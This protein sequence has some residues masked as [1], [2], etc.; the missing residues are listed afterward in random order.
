MKT[1]YSVLFLLFA[2]VQVSA[3][4]NSS[5]KSLL[6]EI[7]EK[8]AKQAFNDSFAKN[9]SV[10]AAAHEYRTVHEQVLSARGDTTNCSVL[11]TPANVTIT[12]VVQNNQQST[13]AK[14]KSC[15]IS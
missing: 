10:E 9:K 11:V 6:E 4:D 8:R 15:I 14:S 3:M 2:A 1:K 7:A 12:R 5:S 13:Q